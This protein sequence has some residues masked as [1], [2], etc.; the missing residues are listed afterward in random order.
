MGPAC[1]ASGKSQNQNMHFSR[2]ISKEYNPEAMSPKLSVAGNSWAPTCQDKISAALLNR[3]FK[4]RKP[5]RQHSSRYFLIY[6][7]FYSNKN[8]I[9]DSEVIHNSL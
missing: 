2:T 1:E 3:T 9:W 4:K 5:N 8:N 7:R 6:F